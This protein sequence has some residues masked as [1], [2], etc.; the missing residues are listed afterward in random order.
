MNPQVTTVSKYFLGFWQNYKRAK[1]KELSGTKED[2]IKVNEIISKLAFFYEKI[3]NYIDYREEHLIRKNAIE[4]SLRR[5]LLPG[6]SGDKISLHLVQE[7]MRAGYIKNASVPEAKIKEV[8]QIINKYIYIYQQALEKHKSLDSK[9]TL[10]WILGV[11]AAELDENITSFAKEQLLIDYMYHIVKDRIELSRKNIP[12][13]ELNVQIYI[14]VQRALI[15]SDNDMI[16]YRLLKIFYPVDH[17]NYQAYLD[18][19]I[20]NFPKIIENFEYHL[21]HHL[22]D[23]IVRVLKKYATIFNILDDVISENFNDFERI[24]AKPVLFEQRIRDACQKKYKKIRVIL[25]RSIVRSIIYIFLTKM[26]LVLILELPMD[27]YIYKEFSWLSLVINVLVPPLLMF[28]IALTIRAPSQDNTQKIISVLNEVTYPVRGNITKH[29]IRPK[30]SRKGF[31][32]LV[33]NILYLATFIFSFSMIIYMLRKLN[34][35]GVSILIFLFFLSLV[36]FFGI[37][38]RQSARDLV[39]VDKRENIFTFIFEFLSLPIIKVG[40][41]LTE[42]F[43]KI[44]VLLYI[45]DFIIEAPFQAFI[46]LIEDWFSFLKEKK[47]EIY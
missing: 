8:A 4:R 21:K 26:L 12:E 14:G 19:V 27:I 32:N 18:N 43:S 40:K 31:F 30:R 6:S 24:V 20:D 15:K 45:F 44:N 25:R 23:R 22:R 13:N 39:V 7:L 34:F 5:K 1:Q 46:R 47:D 42:K 38:I 35:N 17:Q 36:S 28:L 29:V 37:R 3:R 16:K 11:M 9:K 33:F 41:F 2:V 10:K